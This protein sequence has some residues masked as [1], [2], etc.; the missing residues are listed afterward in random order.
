M[1]FVS[2]T[3]QVELQVDEFE[4]LPST[5][6]ANTGTLSLP[7]TATAQGLTLVPFFA[8]LELTLPLSSQLELMFVVPCTTQI[9]Q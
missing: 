8:Q 1:Y 4:P 7:V 6:G 5:G 9:N 2:E 3:A